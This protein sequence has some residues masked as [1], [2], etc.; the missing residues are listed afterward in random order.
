MN[1][2]F[3]RF[4][5]IPENERSTEYIGSG[6]GQIPNKILD[7][8]S[9]YECILD[10]DNIPRIIVPRLTKTTMDTLYGMMCYNTKNIYLVSGDI[11]GVGT[12]GEPLL[13][14]IKIV[15]KLDKQIFFNN[16]DS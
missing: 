12:D 15:R 3:I 13:K 11:V 9:V 5:E 14:N 7:G 4:G 16:V 1:E 6:D 2:Y 8:V 10:K